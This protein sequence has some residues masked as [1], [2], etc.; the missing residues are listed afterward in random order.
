MDAQGTPTEGLNVLWEMTPSQRPPAEFSPVIGDSSGG[1]S[2]VKLSSCSLPG[3]KLSEAMLLGD[4]MLGEILPGGLMLAATLFGASGGDER[5]VAI[6]SRSLE[7]SLA[8]W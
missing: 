8:K 7:G 4:L 6:S 2:F 3:A 5:S 1:G